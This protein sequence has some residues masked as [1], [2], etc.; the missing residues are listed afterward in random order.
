M[1]YPI[2]NRYNNKFDV[3]GFYLKF[4]DEVFIDSK[5][6]TE[7]TVEFPI[8]I[9]VF[10]IKKNYKKWIKLIDAFSID[11]INYGLYGSPQKD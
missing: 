1:I 9:G 11:K 10:K 6:N 2:T 5:R 3:N 4:K 7:F 8:R